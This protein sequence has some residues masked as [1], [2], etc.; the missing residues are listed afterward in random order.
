MNEI[1]IP[2]LV[3]AGTHSNVGKT[4]IVCALASLFNERG[5]KTKLFKCGPDYLDPT[6]HQRASGSSS[7][8]LD[9]WMM[10]SESLKSSFY[11]ASK[12]Y[13]LAIIEGVMGLY[14]GHSPTSEAGSSAEIAKILNAPVVLV[15]DASGMARSIAALVKGFKDFD[16]ELNFAGVICNRV[17]SERHLNLLKM[18][19]EDTKVF[20]GLKKGELTY[21]GRHLGLTTASKKLVNEEVFN[22]WKEKADELIDTNALYDLAKS[23]SKVNFNEKVT[24]KIAPRCKLAYAID[25][26]FHFYYEENINLLKSYGAE[27]I[28]FSPLKDKELPQGVQ[29]VIIGGGYPEVHAKA[30]SE[31]VSMLKSLR[32]FKGPIYAE[33]GGLMYL[34]ESIVDLENNKYEMVG[35]LQGQAKMENKLQA[36]GYV[37]VELKEDSIIGPK[38][39]RFRGHQFRYSNLIK[40]DDVP[41]IFSLRKK[42]NKEVSKEGYKNGRV[43]GSYVHAHFGSNPLLAKYLVENC[44][45]NEI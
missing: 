4:T 35:L 32:E 15:S 10:G 36:L 41:L 20:G 2:R 19:I 5:I 29:G 1:N 8:N 45:K 13:D 23:T 14:D 25:D 21:P 27:L 12:G 31:N 6:Y 9:S 16:P 24:D 43:L 30:L 7:V 22:Y 34:S 39:V 11:H 17:G 28:A 37:E 40:T 44:L 3:I 18:A 26:A 42:R 33:C 38:G